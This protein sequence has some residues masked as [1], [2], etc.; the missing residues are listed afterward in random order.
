MGMV[1]LMTRSDQRVQCEKKILDVVTKAVNL[2]D[3]NLKVMPFGSVE[4]GFSGSNTNYNILV[5]T[6]EW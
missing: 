4:Y 1:D 6:R 2:F 3:P 5:D